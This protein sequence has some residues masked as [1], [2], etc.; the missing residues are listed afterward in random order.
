MVSKLHRDGE[1]MTSGI[2]DEELKALLTQYRVG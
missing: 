1:L 2:E